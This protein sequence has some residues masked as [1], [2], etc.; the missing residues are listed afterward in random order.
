[1]VAFKVAVDGLLHLSVTLAGLKVGVPSVLLL[2]VV[3]V[4]VIDVGLVAQATG[5]V[6]PIVPTLD[7]PANAG[8]TF[9]PKADAN[10]AMAISRLYLVIAP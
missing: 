4:N 2:S 5:T 10:N 7:V 3:T 6:P 9:T 8:A 1:M